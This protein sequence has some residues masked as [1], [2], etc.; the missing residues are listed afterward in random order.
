MLC[1]MPKFQ[2]SNNILGGF[3]LTV[4]TD[5]MSTDSRH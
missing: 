2:N 1:Q 5:K 4:D 3:W